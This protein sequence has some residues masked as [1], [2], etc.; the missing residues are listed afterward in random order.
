MKVLLR[1][2]IGFAVALTLLS[3]ARGWCGDQSDVRL[4][5]FDSHLSGA[6]T[7]ITALSGGNFADLAVGNTVRLDAL[8]SERQSQ[9]WRA[10][11][12]VFGSSAY[13]QLFGDLSDGSYWVLKI[14]SE[15]LVSLQSEALGAKD[16][17]IPLDQFVSDL[18]IVPRPDSSTVLPAVGEIP[19]LESITSS[20]P[21]E[22]S[23]RVAFL[24]ARL[25]ELLKPVGDYRLSKAPGVPFS[26]SD[27]ATEKTAD[28]SALNDKQ[29]AWLAQLYTQFCVRATGGGGSLKV[30]L[31]SG[32]KGSIDG[33]SKDWVGKAPPSWSELGEAKVKLTVRYCVGIYSSKSVIGKGAGWNVPI[34]H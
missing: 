34:V 5:A 16:L 14:K 19:S 15:Y 31:P 28:L 6:A 33:V 18:P 8:S 21:T 17:V 2:V 12:A 29:R 1:G 13:S 3:G 11:A 30:E 24:S 26:Q 27:F 25:L 20:A 10:A 9:I 22:S 23:A 7:Y 32:G 4:A